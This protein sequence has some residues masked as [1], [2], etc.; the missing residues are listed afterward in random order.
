MKRLSIVSVA[1]VI[2]L[3]LAAAD[4]KSAVGDERE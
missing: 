1:A 3:T 2:T 4:P